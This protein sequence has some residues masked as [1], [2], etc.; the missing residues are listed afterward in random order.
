MEERQRKPAPA[1]KK[2]NQTGLTF[3][4]GCATWA[5]V[6]ALVIGGIVF[7]VSRFRGGEPTP[8]VDNNDPG[9]GGMLDP[10][11]VIGVDDDPVEEEEPLDIAALKEDDVVYHDFLSVLV[12]VD[13]PYFASPAE[14]DMAHLVTFGIWQALQSGE[15]VEYGEQSIMVPQE[16]VEQEIAAVFDGAPPIVHQ[17]V[18]IYGDF[19]YNAENA[20][21]EMPIYGMENMNLPR[22]RSVTPLE[23]SVYEV[24]MDYI[25]SAAQD[26]YEHA[27]GPRPEAVKTVKLTVQGTVGDYRVLSLSAFAQA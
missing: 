3:L 1:G 12:F 21:Y 20:R 6:L 8:P 22:I 11:Y 24:V 4:M 5:V 23:N 26:T 18:S 14:A 27:E 25:D 9:S 17:S 15:Q 19:T 7:V 10:D 2:K 16:A 13:F